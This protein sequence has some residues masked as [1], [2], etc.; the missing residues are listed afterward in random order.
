MKEIQDILK[1]LEES[2]NSKNVDGMSRFG[3]NTYKAFGVPMPALRA[4]AREYKNNHALAVGLW[5]TGIHECRL[6]APLIADPKLTTPLLIQNWVEEFDSWDV[7]DQCCI[8]LIRHMPFAHNKIWEYAPDDREFVRRTAFVLIATLAVHDKKVDNDDFLR[9]LGLIAEYSGDNRTF[10]KKAVNW[11]LRQIG[12]RNFTLNE[13]AAEAAGELA[14]SPLPSARWIGKDA[15]R[16][17]TSQKTLDYIR[18]HR[19]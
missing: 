13:A 1:W 18:D 2:R 5:N 17:L 11:A 3:I 6:M 8:N 19:K 15:L 10:V 12:K 14:S 16:E 7:C 4:K 9:Y